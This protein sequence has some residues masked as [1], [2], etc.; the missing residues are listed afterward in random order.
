MKRT[1]PRNDSPP[2]PPI[3]KRVRL[4]RE[5]ETDAEARALERE[6]ERDFDMPPGAFR[7][8]LDR[9]EGNE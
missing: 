5:R 3:E 4:V 1:R 7:G 2:S 9:D 8:A 6:I